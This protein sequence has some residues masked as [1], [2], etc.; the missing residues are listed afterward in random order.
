MRPSWDGDR[1][2]GFDDV[3][4]RTE[5]EGRVGES[6]GELGEGGLISFEI[7]DDPAKEMGCGDTL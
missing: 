6:D 5:V 1:S 3:D 7:E 2:D 4:R